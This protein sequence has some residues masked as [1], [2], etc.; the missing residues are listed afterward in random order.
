MIVIKR[1]IYI[2]IMTITTI[3]IGIQNIWIAILT[4]IVFAAC[5]VIIDGIWETKSI[6]N[7]HKNDRKIDFKERS[8]RE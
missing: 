3:A 5:Y 2:I 1:I 6:E 7:K 4:L 8:L